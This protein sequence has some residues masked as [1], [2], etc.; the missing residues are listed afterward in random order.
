MVKPKTIIRGD[1]CRLPVKFKDTKAKRAVLRALGIIFSV[2]CP[3]YSYFAVEYLHFGGKAQI[4][5]FMAG[6]TPTV[7]FGIAVFYFIFAAVLL[8]SGRAWC[9]CLVSALAADILGIV[10][11]L[12]FGATG[13][14]FYPWDFEQTGNVSELV[15]FVKFDFTAA[16]VIVV[17][18]SFSFA[19]LTFVLG[20]RLPLGAVIRLPALAAVLACVFVVFSSPQRVTKIINRAGIYMEDTVLQTSN[21]RANGFTAAFTVNVLSA[22]VEMPSGYGENTIKAIMDGREETPASEN[23]ASP[24]IILILSES[25]WDVRLLGG[26]FSD[27]PLECFDTLSSEENVYSGKMYQTGFGG[28]TVRPEFEVIT[29][30]TTDGLPG[31]SVPWRYVTKPLETYVS[32]L[33]DIGYK[34]YGI[35][36]Y[37]SRFYDRKR[38]YPLAGIDETYFEEDLR[39]IEEVECSLV[40]VYDYV[41]DDS[42]VSYIEYFLDRD[43]DGGSPKFIFGISM[44]NHQ[45]FYG[46]YAD[47]G[48]KYE[49]ELMSD[50]MINTVENYAYGVMHADRALGRLAEYVR[51]RERPTVLC[52]FGDHLPSLGADYGAYR[53][54]GLL[55]GNGDGGFTAEEHDI[56]QSTPF[57]VLSNFEMKKDGMLN[58][59]NG[60]RI[61]SYNL[62]NGVFE[63]I[64]AP[65][66]A[67]CSFL[68]DYYEA[69]PYY[70]GRLGLTTDE[71]QKYFVRAH[72]QLTYDRIRGGRYSLD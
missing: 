56:M 47:C 44:E 26:A 5:G 18:L 67:L 63:L 58:E 42:F 1:F 11:H 40:S 48:M 6:R 62:L 64:G 8:L 38:A 30:L 33:K 10:D 37:L 23:F 19:V 25:F 46:K 55:A 12:K 27:D 59:G 13:D 51:N 2:L 28:G 53:Q 57:I 71:E 68:S 60:N 52:L 14:Y 54:S 66:T 17:V 34:T 31:G 70:N 69:L 41:S 39:K 22:N 49:N 43:A 3:L 7:L 45:S 21:Y 15:K 65:R 35:H 72:R 9:A 20:T 16:A 4:F 36:P 50:E 29:G 32:T 61:S 24:D